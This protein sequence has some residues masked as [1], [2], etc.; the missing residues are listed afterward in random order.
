MEPKKRTFEFA[1]TMFIFYFLSSSLV[2]WFNGLAFQD[3]GFYIIVLVLCLISLFWVIKIIKEPH[4]IKSK[5]SDAS[6][7]LTILGFV[8]LILTL[9]T[10]EDSEEVLISIYFFLVSVS[11]AGLIKWYKVTGVEENEELVIKI[12]EEK[13]ENNKEELTDIERLRIVI[14]EALSVTPT[15]TND[16]SYLLHSEQL[17]DEIITDEIEAPKNITTQMIAVINHYK[18][19]VTR[20]IKTKKI[21]STLNDLEATLKMVEDTLIQIYDIGIDS[22]IS[23]IETDSATFEKL[24][25]LE[26]LKE[27]DFKLD[28]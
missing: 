14:K 5:S 27:S 8:I 25:E 9:P 24:V 13:E 3:L 4:L 15:G 20:R 26:G 19:L 7:F 12:I 18:D 22:Q 10:A 23:E 16:Y 6:A 1:S 21:V 11:M 17:I 2:N 28:E